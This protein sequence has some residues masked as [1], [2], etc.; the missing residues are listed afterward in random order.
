LDLIRENAMKVLVTGA[1]G[2]LGGYLVEQ[3]VKHKHTV[4]AAVRPTSSRKV[5]ENLPVE[6]VVG[7]MNNSRSL[8][9]MIE[10]IDAVIHSAVATGGTLEYMEKVNI[11]GTKIMLDLARKAEVKRF[12]FLSSLVVYDINS[13]PKNSL[14]DESFEL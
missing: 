1:S 9:K 14:I 7:D 6:I 4:R 10:G 5:L 2:F 13:I 11:E 3:L 8:A 12:V